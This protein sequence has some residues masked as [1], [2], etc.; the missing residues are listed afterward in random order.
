MPDID[1]GNGDKA[2]DQT[3]ESQDREGLWSQEKEAELEL[4][5]T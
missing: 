5:G 4:K 1:L 2:V 3:D